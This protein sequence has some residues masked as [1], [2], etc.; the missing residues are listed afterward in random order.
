M[1]REAQCQCIWAGESGQCK[2]LLETAELIVRG[3]FRRV[4]PISSMTDIAVDGDNLTFCVGADKVALTL[5]AA[6]ARSWAK[7]LTTA[8]PTLASKLGIS[9]DSQLLLIGESD[10]EE[11]S[12]A[13][14]GA[15]TRSST[16]PGLIV[17]CV[18]TQAELDQALHRATAYSSKP[19]IWIVYP[20][21]AGTPL[22]ESVIRN[23]LR[24]QGFID[25][26]VASVDATYT[27]LRFIKRM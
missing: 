21:G 1:G 13:L 22:P 20:K 7:K 19:P 16:I 17:A 10:S 26:K 2:V 5:G 9:S 18:H 23:T 3:A 14:A 25:T 8:P 12:S 4:I 27:A 15:A 11:L 6:Q 24:S